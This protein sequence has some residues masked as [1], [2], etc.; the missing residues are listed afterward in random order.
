MPA[1][2]IPSEVKMPANVNVADVANAAS[3]MQ[4]WL[5]WLLIAIA[6]LAVVLFII[7]PLVRKLKHKKL[8]VQE[9]SELKKDLMVWH[10]LSQLVRGGDEHQKAKRA[11]TDGIFKI[12]FLFDQGIQMIKNHNHTLYDQPW[13][14]I[15]GEPQSGKSSLLRNSEQELVVSAED[16][17][18]PEE[19]KSLPLRLWMGA[20]AVVCDINGRT[21]F[22]RWL[23]G[24]SAEWAY[25]T[26]LINKKHHKKPLDGV[27]L[28]IPADALLADDD[29]LT[30]QK[31]VLISTELGQLTRTI[32]MYVPVYV[33]V[34]KTDMINGFSEYVMAISEDLRTQS[35]GWLNPNGGEKYDAAVF[36]KFWEDLIVKLR[37]G[38]EKSMVSKNV[39]SHMS[40]QSSRIELTGKIFMFPD[41][42]DKIYQNLAFYLKA[43]FGDGN[44]HGTENTLLQGV[45]FTSAEEGDF[46]LSQTLADMCEQK[47]D[48]V[49]ISRK[50]VHS[51][52]PFFIRKLFQNLIFQPSVNSALT[53]ATVFKRNVPKFLACFGM[54]ALSIWWGLT[55][56]LEA[57]G[58]KDSLEPVTNYYSSVTELIKN[59]SIFSSSLLKKMPDGTIVINQ[60]PLINSNISRINFYSE[61][62]SQRERPVTAPFGF[63][64]SSLLLFGNEPGMGYADKAFIMNQLFGIMVRMPLIRLVGEKFATDNSNPPLTKILR[65]AIR[66]YTYLGYVEK[67]DYTELMQTADKFNIRSI[68]E[69]LMP[70]VLLD[71]VVLLDSYLPKYDKKY[72]ATIDSVYM[73]SD[74][75]SKGAYQASLMM[76]RSWYHLDAYPDSMFAKFQS[77]VHALRSLGK[78]SEELLEGVKQIDTLQSVDE[79][80]EIVARWDELIAEQREYGHR[81]DNIAGQITTAMNLK[82]TGKDKLRE[83]MWTENIIPMNV[84]LQK[85]ADEYKNLM[86]EDFKFVEEITLPYS[87]DE[88]IIHVRK[89][90]ADKR[91]YTKKVID[92][93]IKDIRQAIN[94]FKFE[95][96]L[97]WQFQVED[98][99][100]ADYLFKILSEAYDIID[101]LVTPTE[102]KVSQADFESSWSALRA[103][104]QTVSANYKHFIEPFAK[105]E[106]LKP[107]FDAISQIL[108]AKIELCQYMI[109]DYKLKILPETVSELRAFVAR[110]APEDDIFS[111][112]Q[113]L[114]KE[115]MG[116]LS[117]LKDFDPRVVKNR[118]FELF[119]T[120]QKFLASDEKKD[121]QKAEKGN[122]SI[123]FHEF[124]S[125]EN[126]KYMFES[127]LQDY[128]QYWGSFPEHIFE[129]VQSWSEFKGIAETTKAYNVNSLLQQVYSTC[130]SILKDMDDQIMSPSLRKI[131]A[132]YVVSLNDKM[133]V[134]SPLFTKAGEKTL[135]SW[136]E[137]PEDPIEAWRQIIG[138]PDRTLKNSLFNVYT[139]KTRSKVDWWND[140]VS[141]G[142][143]MLRH[144]NERSVETEYVQLIQ[145]MRAMPLCKDCGVKK[146]IPVAELKKLST[147][148]SSIAP[149]P[150]SEEDG[151]SAEESAPLFDKN[152]DIFKDLDTLAWAKEILKV[153]G[154]LTNEKKPLRWTMYQASAE[155]Q[156]ALLSAKD[157]PAI[158]RFRYVE[159]V[160]KDVP[161]IKGKKIEKAKRY[162][163]ASTKDSLI[164]QG[165]AEQ[166]VTINFYKISSD[167]KPEASISFKNEPWSIFKIYLKNGIS[168]DPESDVKYIPLH[169]KDPIDGKVYVYYVLLKFNQKEF[170]SAEEWPSKQDWDNGA[171]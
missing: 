74:D 40:L 163:T 120:A 167:E 62:L 114:A 43:I 42:F 148:L 50:Y 72:T 25:I 30:K 71:T 26:R 39:T 145:S 110:L 44:F 45:F 95:P 91:S 104:I 159:V 56:Y 113:R 23:N 129:D 13:Y 107:Y 138:T 100:E 153:A 33:V 99:D 17:K 118:L 151:K 98:P 86:N 144:E 92:S 147:L 150:V 73:H 27:I 5:K 4:G 164:G 52:K 139:D 160:T 24:S 16:E 94:K 69:Y 157:V 53:A 55:G 11:L 32:G 93:Q 31:A 60:D 131:K 158:N 125:Y 14:M 127:Y 85:S 136:A 88:D 54:V 156:N 133:K 170:V 8:K 124:A 36:A 152:L 115:N 9:T 20:K 149:Q 79:L 70:D 65:S 64:L 134:L 108:E 21:F 6:V 90:V 81:I 83:K 143:E 63:K 7:V 96:L 80:R 78:G 38:S 84:L 140:F 166:N 61:V 58:L 59:G 128:I 75:Y 112:S 46:T 28:T 171:E 132:E 105:N 48:E 142:I 97:Q 41:N 161:K 89:A 168:A 103:K 119:R 68:I 1:I 51:R 12:N 66:S 122:R 137:L 87:A 101:D 102:E 82:F 135:M 146:V 19:I 76:L 47:V 162:S 35:F 18:T 130:L 106:T 29:S 154:L 123:Q 37:I 126:A 77:L 22:D 3:G 116:N 165:G 111:F 155:M 141:N 2:N 15:L 109:L 67:E 121:E 34:T 117:Y 49:P 169:V 57:D 10:H